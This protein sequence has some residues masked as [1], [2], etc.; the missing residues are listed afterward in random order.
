MAT[1]KQLAAL[2]K[3][4]AARSKKT[5]KKPVTKKRV[6]TRKKT[7]R[8]NPSYYGVIIETKNGTAYLSK[9]GADGP[10]VE[11]EAS[12]ALKLCRNGAEALKYAIFNLRPKGVIKVDAVILG[13]PSKK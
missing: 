10:H 7:V 11:V 3:A 8:R 13:S 2:K 12:K 6:T 4:R 9:W 5:V 1:A